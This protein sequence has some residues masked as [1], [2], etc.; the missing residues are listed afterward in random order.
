MKKIEP[1]AG[2][3]SVRD[4]LQVYQTVFTKLEF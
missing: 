1:K 2:Q 3:E 4:Y